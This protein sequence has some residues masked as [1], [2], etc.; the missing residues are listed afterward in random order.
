MQFNLVDKEWIPVKRRDGTETMIAPWQITDGFDTNPIIA[1]NATRADFN[2]ALIQFLIGL[3]QTMAAPANKIEWK[4]K[5]M[6]PPLSKELQT[7]FSTVRHAFELGG[8]GTRFMQEIEQLEVEVR[9]ID[10][11]LIDMPGENAR[12]RNT[13]HFVK[14]NTV[15]AMCPS[16]CATA[17]FTMQT[18]APAGGAGFRTSLRGGGPLTTLV[19]G[20]QD[21]DLL[22]HLIWLNVLESDVF[23]RV[24]ANTACANENDKFPWLGETRTSESKA[25]VETTPE[26]AHPVMMFWAMPR[27]IRLNMTSLK[28]GVCDLCGKSSDHLI[29]EYQDKNYGMDFTGAWLHP[30]SPYS[31]NKDGLPLPAHAQPGGVSYRHWLGLVQANAKEGRVPARIIHEFQENRQHNLKDCQFR[32][33]AFGYDMDNMKA[34]CWYEAKMPLLCVEPALRGEYENS[35]AGMVK[36]AVE[37]A[38]N[39]Q[40]A[41]K[42]AWFKRPGDVKGDTSFISNSFWQNTEPAFYEALHNLKKTLESDADCMG[43]R[44]EWHASLC[45]E[46]LKLFDAYAWDGP[47]ED[48]DPKRVVIARQELQYFNKSKKIKGLLDLPVEQQPSGGAKKKSGQLIAQHG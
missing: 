11:L 33:W 9:G 26:D 36:A 24:C 16:C 31:Y 41:V 37:I 10:G 17:L 12:K 5:L 44:K 6:K 4:M 13:D 40:I 45:N 38:K 21:Y 23:L 18:N 43:V 29:Q 27:R 20:S 30:L 35:I 25:G 46:A 7:M 32:L 2:G 47:I 34:R 1:L 8:D 19:L 14:R 28:A 3:V 48:T 39:V 22:W 15:N 42:K